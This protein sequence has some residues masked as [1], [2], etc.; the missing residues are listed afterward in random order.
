MKEKSL[1]PNIAIALCILFIGIFAYIATIIS[2]DTIIGFDQPIIAIVQSREAPWLTPIMNGFSFVGSTKVVMVLI[3]A[4]TAL[5]FWGFRAHS[6]AYFFFFATVGTSALN[7]TLKFIFKRERPEFHRLADAVGYSFPS[8][9]TMM[10]FT[11]YAIAVILLWRKIRVPAGKIALLAFAVFMFG[12]IALSR[13]YLGVHYPSDIAGGIVAS[14]FWVVF[15][16]FIFD[17]YQRRKKQ[18]LVNS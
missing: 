1:R 10:A 18:G 7:Q 16:V 13:I 8:G 17:F 11:L 9:H 3:I 6:S 12:M 14:A 2:R 5:L 15:T 4:V